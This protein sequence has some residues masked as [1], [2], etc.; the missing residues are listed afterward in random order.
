MT[1]TQAWITALRLRTLPLSISGVT[2]GSLIALSKSIFDWKVFFLALT[3]TLFLQILSNLANDYGDNQNGADNLDRIG[4]ERMVQSGII[5]AREMKRM[6]LLFA[7]MASVSGVSLL[8]ISHLDIFSVSFFILLILGILAIWA[9]LNYTIGNNPYG[10]SGWGDLSVFIFFGLLSVAGTYY[11]HAG[12]I[13][14][15]IFLPAISIGAL[16]VGVL[17]INNMRD[18]ENDK[19]SGKN[20]LVVKIGVSKAKYYHMVLLATALIASLLY[21]FVNHIDYP[22]Y[23]FVFIFI[24]L[25]KHLLHIFHFQNP[26][27]IDQELKK[28]ALITILFS[29][30]FG[31]VIN[32]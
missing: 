1:K 7:T 11:L 22:G 8:L 4:P 3:T 13:S 14:I 2:I 18:H 19:A 17:N 25:T 10:Y 28:L 12:E 24:P 21:L 20:T 31:T 5:S 23:L 26:S 15:D 27:L 32:I 16:S 29:L 30:T 6:I 9:A